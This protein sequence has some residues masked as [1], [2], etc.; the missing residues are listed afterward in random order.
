MRNKNK[1]QEKEEG[2]KA[3]KETENKEEERGRI[4]RSQLHWHTCD[5]ERFSISIVCQY[6]KVNYALHCLCNG[7]QRALNAI[8]C[9]DLLVLQ[10]CF[11]GFVCSRVQAFQFVSRCDTSLSSQLPFIIWQLLLRAVTPWNV[12]ILDSADLYPKLSV[13]IFGFNLESGL[14][15]DWNVWLDSQAMK[16]IVGRHAFKSW[17]TTQKW[18]HSCDASSLVSL[19]QLGQSLTCVQIEV[20]NQFHVHDK[21]LVNSSGYW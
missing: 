17:L 5:Q 11:I 7:F 12:Q 15:V 4:R 8:L 13:R 10:F 3:K 20:S 6:R 21:T 1:K 19:R 16:C 2:K 9:E 18:V 14:R